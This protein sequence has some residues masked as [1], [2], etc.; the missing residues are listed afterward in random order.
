MLKKIVGIAAAAACAFS[1]AGCAAPQQQEPDHSQ[2]QVN[3]AGVSSSDSE[4]A[5]G[6]GDSSASGSAEAAVPTA[7]ELRAK[8]NIS[9]DYRADFNHGEKGAACQKYIVLH[10]TEVNASASS[11]VSS[12]EGSGNK[13]AS[14]FIVNKDGSIV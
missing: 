14:Q 7:D 4:S 2:L 5:D 8:L 9:E 3:D 10:D 12:W 1:F 11:I 13:V 6:R